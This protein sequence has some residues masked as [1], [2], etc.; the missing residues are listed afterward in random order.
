MVSRGAVA[1]CPDALELRSDRGVV[2]GPA[3]RDQQV[4]VV[5][6]GSN[7][8]AVEPQAALA[9]CRYRL[10]PPLPR[11]RRA[12]PMTRRPAFVALLL[13][14]AATT[15]PATAQ[16]P[17]APANG[18]QIVDGNVVLRW[19]LDPGRYSRCVQFASRP[20]TSYPGGPFLA[21]T[22]TTCFLG[23]QDL[24]YLLVDLSIRRY[25]WHVQTGREGMEDPE[26]VWG[27]TAYF[28]S[29][30]PP[31]PPRPSSCSRKAAAVMANDVLLPY[32]EKRYPRYYKG[33]T[34]WEPSGPICRDL[35]G[36]G[37]REMIVRLLC[38]TGGSLSPWAI[39]KHD[40]SRQWRM[41]YA[42]I[43]D[44]V[45]RLSV[46][47]RVVRTMLPAPYEGGCTR[48][49]RYREVRSSSSRFRSRLTRRSR[50]RR[51]C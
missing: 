11:A 7:G 33:V 42:Q 21:P 12:S 35:D 29:V 15:S 44:T 50:L 36:D 6:L 28:D 8:A 48:Y 19:T 27:P 23:P 25:Y 26:E 14:F 22:T 34:E 37:D 46:R 17:V 49:V 10:S 31:P 43:R 40:P 51:A 39:F 5:A 2:A 45:F 1:R 24:A 38:C 3:Q 16:T 13:A 20:E 18:A 32:A 30:E 47:R 4:E 41:A 9:C